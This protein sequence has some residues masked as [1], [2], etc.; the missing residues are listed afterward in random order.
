MTLKI[1]KVIFIILCMN[2]IK[3]IIR[4]LY[5]MLCI[6]SE[7]QRYYHEYVGN[8]VKEHVG[9]YCNKKQRIGYK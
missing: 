4:V 5:D 6:C 2:N 9:M 8:I 1:L 3:L 7:M